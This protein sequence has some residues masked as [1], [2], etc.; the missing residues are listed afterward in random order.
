VIQVTLLA[1]YANHRPTLSGIV[2]WTVAEVVDPTDP[3][4][5]IAVT[6]TGTEAAINTLLAD[7]S[8]YVRLPDSG[9]RI[10]S[11]SVD[12]DTYAIQGFAIITPQKG[13]AHVTNLNNSGDGSLRAALESGAGQVVFDVGGTITLTSS[14]EPS[15][16]IVDASTAPDYVIIQTDPGFG[17]PA[18]WCG[19][20]T[21]L[22]YLIV[23]PGAPATQSSTCRAVSM[24]GAVN[25]A[26][27]HCDFAWSTDEN[28]TGYPVQ[29]LTIQWC[30]IYEG[31]WHSTHPD[32]PHSKGAVLNGTN[33]NVHH[34]LW[35][36]NDQRN[37]R[38]YDVVGGGVVDIANNV[39]YD[40]G[41]GAVGVSRDE[42]YTQIN[43]RA[44]Y[45][46]AGLSTHATHPIIT[47]AGTG[48]DMPAIYVSENVIPEMLTLMHEDL[49]PGLV[50]TAFP[51]PDVGLT[52][53]E[54]AFEDVLAGA[55]A[56]PTARDPHALRIATD[57]FEGTG[58]L[59]D[60]P[61]VL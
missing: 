25:V 21:L 41:T 60:T 7:T 37:P 6:V 16:V 52:S 58:V 47:P 8:N 19:D 22:R 42:G 9:I 34:T 43:I 51:A 46:K 53:A 54:Q 11:G 15:N 36:H 26:F 32:G 28:V 38:V 27:D 59:K 10:K 18:F 55:G 5:Q 50:Q 13:I 57:V 45:Y 23:R 20:N 39:V 1:P 31:L 29:N 40:W 2:D 30:F 49:Q 17:G 3:P 44:N 35:A 61:P 48:S 33:I 12:A 56:W 4:D 24:A 14:L